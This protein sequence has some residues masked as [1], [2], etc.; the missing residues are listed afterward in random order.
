MRGLSALL[1]LL[2]HA[3]AS[4]EPEWDPERAPPTLE[5]SPEELDRL[6]AG[7]TIYRHEA[8]EDR[9]VGVAAVA[10]RAAPEAIW[11]HITDYDAYVR[12]L[13]YVTASRTVGTDGRRT[14]CALE[15]TTLG[16]V[17]RYE[18]ENWAWPERGYLNWAL[19]PAAGNPLQGA[20]GSWQVSPFTGTL[21]P[22]SPPLT[23]LSYRTEVT[24]S[25]WIPDFLQARA[26]DRG[27]PTLVRLIR[28][29]AEA[30]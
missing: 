8:Y 2:S 27:L 10:T 11:R 4:A 14:T 23:L 13:P 12:F 17:T 16:V 20:T 30:E 3:A 24:M 28:R 21:P 22:D 26:A 5:F 25:W 6:A 15:L 18:M 29:Q 9:V 7:G 19:S 1:L